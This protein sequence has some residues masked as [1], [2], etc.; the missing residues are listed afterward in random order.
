[1]I[2]RPIHAL[3]LALVFIVGFLSGLSVQIKAAVVKAAVCHQT[4]QEQPQ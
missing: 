1:M 4:T 3:I 2:P